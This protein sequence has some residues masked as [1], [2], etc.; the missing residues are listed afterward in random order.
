M[1]PRSSRHRQPGQSVDPPGQPSLDSTDRMTNRSAMVRAVYSETR[2]SIKKEA[3]ASGPLAMQQRSPHE[4]FVGTVRHV[5]LAT[6]KLLGAVDLFGVI[7]QMRLDRL[8][9]DKLERETQVLEKELSF[10]DQ[11]RITELPRLFSEVMNSSGSSAS[12]AKCPSIATMT[13]DMQSAKAKLE[14]LK[15]GLE[16]QLNEL[17]TLSSGMRGS[18]VGVQECLNHLG[19]T[20]EG[21]DQDVG[22]FH[23]KLLE[24]IKGTREDTTA[25]VANNDADGNRLGSVVTERAEVAGAQVTLP[26]SDSCEGSSPTSLMNRSANASDRRTAS[27]WRKAAIAMAF[28]R[29]IFT[30]NFETIQTLVREVSELS[31]SLGGE[32]LI[33]PYL[34]PGEADDEAPACAQPQT[35]TESVTGS[36]SVPREK[37]EAGKRGAPTGADCTTVS[38]DEHSL[39]AKYVCVRP[40][41]RG[42]LGDD[43]PSIRRVSALVPREENPHSLRALREAAQRESHNVEE[44]DDYHELLSQ[45]DDLFCSDKFLRQPFA[46]QRVT[47]SALSPSW[48]PPINKQWGRK[49][50]EQPV[51]D[52]GRRTYMG[53]STESRPTPRKPVDRLY[54]SNVG[55]CMESRPSPRKPVDSFCYTNPGR[56]TESRPSPRKIVDNSWSTIEHVVA[57]RARRHL[58]FKDLWPGVYAYDG[59]MAFEAA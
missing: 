5:R 14:S 35:L 45:M 12:S 9:R 31:V 24:E 2:Q 16:E 44:V 11:P 30:E 26:R 39:E 33:A 6:R 13:E 48:L 4:R 29:Q 36:A 8:E 17:G 42:E 32:P 47:M 15:A 41:F 28:Q 46:P 22:K 53:G 37:V 3:E 56:C 19:M 57:E 25:D 40:V 10:G 55:R 58:R 50:T 18:I 1:A 20:M 27:I 49:Q 51:A 52:L 43:A 34:D 21:V 7:K 23:S 54:C 59:E 38:A